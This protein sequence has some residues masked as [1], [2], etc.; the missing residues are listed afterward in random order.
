MVDSRVCGLGA[1]LRQISQV[2]RP[3]MELRC[4]RSTDALIQMLLAVLHAEHPHIYRLQPL[5]ACL[6]RRA[7]W[8]PRSHFLERHIVASWLCVHEQRN[9]CRGQFIERN[10]VRHLGHI[11][12]GIGFKAATGDAAAAS[13][14]PAA[15]AAGDAQ[16]LE[17]ARQMLADDDDK[18]GRPADFYKRQAPPPSAARSVCERESGGPAPST[19]IERKPGS[20]PTNPP[21]SSQ[22]RT[23]AA[24][25]SRAPAQGRKKAASS[26]GG[27]R[28]CA[29]GEQPD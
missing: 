14:A 22:R 27:G 26:H 8:V 2:V 15:L 6:A 11:V 3:G 10:I 23:Q 28:L 17:V 1:R 7:S 5:R 4:R 12:G 19:R 24:A 18:P 21:G 20:T 16:H 29:D 13:E 9:Y 25:N